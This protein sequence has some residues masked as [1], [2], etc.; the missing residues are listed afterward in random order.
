MIQSLATGL[1]TAAAAL[2]TKTTDKNPGMREPFV[3]EDFFTGHTTAQARFAA[4]NGLK[5]EFR[6]DITGEW[7][8]DTLALH[9]SFEFDDGEKDE[10]TWLFRKL[11]D[12]QYIANR[13]DLLRPVDATIRNGT[14]RYSYSLYLDAAGKNNVVRFIDRITM[15]DAQTLKNRAIVCKFGIPVGLVTGTFHK[16]SSF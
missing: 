2:K 16:Q 7:E 10:K 14:L 4:I 8:N 3:L 6:I 1:T 12:G 13:A 9:E 11:A 5:R 15:A